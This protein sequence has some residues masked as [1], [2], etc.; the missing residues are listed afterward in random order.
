MVLTKLPGPNPIDL[1][2]LRQWFERPY[3]GAVPIRGLDLVAW[4]ETADLLAIKPRLT[5]DPL[6]RWLAN[7]FFPTCHRLFGERFKVRLATFVIPWADI[8]LNNKTD[9]RVPRTRRRNVRL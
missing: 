8:I 7:S 9:P 5:P 6:S 3:G 4:E 2:F 1:N